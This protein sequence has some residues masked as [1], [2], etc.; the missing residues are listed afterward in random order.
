MQP[1]GINYDKERQP[2]EMLAIVTGLKNG[3]GI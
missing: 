1:L 3:N 2:K